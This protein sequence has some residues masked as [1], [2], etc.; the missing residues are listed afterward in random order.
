MS[1]GAV[2]IIGVASMTMIA[3]AHSAEVVVFAAGSLR[4]PLVDMAKDWQAEHPSEEVRFVFGASGLL[5]ERLAKGEH[6]D[7]FASANMEHPE[8]LREAGLARPVQRFATN[9]MCV[10]ARPGVDVTADN[11]LSRMLDPALKLGT[12]TPRADPSGDYAWQVFRRIEEAGNKG[13]F[14]SLSAKALQPAG[15]PQSP[16]PADRSVYAALTESGQ[17]DLFLTY[18]TNA[19]QAVRES[20]SL[21]F[22]KVPAVFNVEASYGVA[23]LN[24]A[25]QQAAAFAEHMLSPR[26]QAVLIRY[27]FGPR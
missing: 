13:A 4:A 6:A 16:P 19:A 23:L 5:K 26:G 11:L 7:L 15:G 27:G 2:W 14:A 25:S 21:R 3:A 1:R 12:S 10:L 18:C 22:V 9:S 8:A 20:P 24:G 17:A